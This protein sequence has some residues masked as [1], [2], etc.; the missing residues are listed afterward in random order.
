MIYLT[1]V[2][3]AETAVSSKEID[4]FIEGIARGE[5]EAFEALYNSARVSVYAFALSFL[6]NSYDAEDVLHDCFVSVW[7]SATAYRSSGKPLAWI[8][9]I[10]KN[11]CLMKI[12]ESW[13]TSDISE[14][15]MERSLG[16]F[17]NASFE[18]KIIVEACMKILS[19]EERQIVTLHAVSGFKHREIAGFLDIP[20]PTVLS[21]YNRAL[22]KLRKYLTEERENDEE[23]H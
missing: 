3:S 15:E 16:S 6:K 14:E 12:R 13:L 21:R 22:K 2:N 18:D 17:D 11:L 19:D 9:T 8:L 4:S 23:Q 20:L 10:T 5:K 1:S 7:S